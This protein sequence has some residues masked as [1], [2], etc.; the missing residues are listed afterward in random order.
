LAE[1]CREAGVNDAAALLELEQKA[2]QAF[3]LEQELQQLGA[4]LAE[5][6]EGDDIDALVE[7]ARGSDKGLV[8]ARLAELEDLIALREDEA[9]D[10][11]REVSELEL[12]LRHY[13]GRDGAD[14]AQDLAATV[15]RLAEL[16]ASWL[17]RRLAVTVLERVVD[18]YREKHQ[19]PVL[20]RASELFGRFSLGR[21]TRL[22][23]GLEETRL[24][25]IEAI[26]GKALE[27][28]QLSAGTR[29]QLF[30]ALKLASLEQ[31]LTKA[32]PLPLVLDDVLVEWD[33]ERAKVAL[34]VL[35]EC[36]EKQQILLFT[37]QAT[38]VAAAESLG[39]RRILIHRLVPRSRSESV[40]LAA[41]TV[42]T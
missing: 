27:L 24:E 6:C 29:M 10:A 14:A 33:E 20:S 39:D 30:L 13:E 18:Q 35:A 1:L 41:G 21:Y 28:E 23:V 7:E 36:S 38:H 16:S 40:D 31:Y 8:A 3:A 34:K 19:D 11:E 5:V 17:R 15:A 42:E 12:G 25:C 26:D 4:R 37:H 32:P 2:E 22:Q 9:R